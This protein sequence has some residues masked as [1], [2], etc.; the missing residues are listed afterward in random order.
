[1]MTTKQ[2]IDSF[3]N[4]HGYANADTLFIKHLRNGGL[5]DMQ[6]ATVIVAMDTICR[7][8]MDT[9]KPC[10]CERDE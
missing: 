3:N 7:D 10:N 8:C 9:V 5:T 1:M 6:I 2:I 4:Q